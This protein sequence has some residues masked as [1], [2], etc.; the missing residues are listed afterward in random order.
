MGHSSR[1]AVI[2]GGVSPLHPWAET[3]PTR[4][5]RAEVSGDA[6]EV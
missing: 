5:P 3:L 2:G 1:G 6:A 4:Q